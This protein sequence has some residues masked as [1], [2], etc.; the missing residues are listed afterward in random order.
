MLPEGT[1]AVIEVSLLTVN[2]VTG[3]P[4]MVTAVAPVKPEPVIVIEV[5]TV[6]DVGVNEVIIGSPITFLCMENVDVFSIT[7]VKSGRPSPSTSKAVPLTLIVGISVLK[8]SVLENDK[9]EVEAL[10][11]I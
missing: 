5:P 10:L 6:P 1:T 7:D 8:A 11:E 4:L 2:E 3:F 9:L